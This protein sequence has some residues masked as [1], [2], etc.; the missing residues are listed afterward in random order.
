MRI[1]R[2]VLI[3]PH[4]SLPAG[5]H[6]FDPGTQAFTRRDEGRPIVIGDGSWLASGC[7][8]TNGVRI[9]KCNLICANAVVTHDTPDYAI[10]A[11]TPARRIG[12]IDPETG[13]YHW[14]KRN[15]VES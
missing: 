13:D 6:R 11:G 14:E 3:G 12:R 9:G 15:G 1:G 4:C 7:T 5:N 8:V 10:M 2:N